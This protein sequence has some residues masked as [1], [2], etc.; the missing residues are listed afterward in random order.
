MGAWQCWHLQ[1]TVVTGRTRGLPQ[2]G[3]V[4]F[5]MALVSSVARDFEQKTQVK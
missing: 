5:A 1:R 2:S 4:A 3:H